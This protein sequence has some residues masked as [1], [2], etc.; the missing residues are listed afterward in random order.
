M[1]CL[2]SHFRGQLRDRKTYQNRKSSTSGGSHV[3]AWSRV[4]ADT[5]ADCGWGLTRYVQEVKLR[6]HCNTHPAPGQS[7]QSEVEAECATVLNIKALNVYIYRGTTEITE[8]IRQETQ[9][10]KKSTKFKHFKRYLSKGEGH[11]SWWPRDSIICIRKYRTHHIP[12]LH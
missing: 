9:N 10:T 11:W 3:R 4:D 7:L 6:H 2:I 8:C 12:K 1:K 5:G